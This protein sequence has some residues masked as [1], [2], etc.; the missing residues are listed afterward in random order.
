MSK[1]GQLLCIEVFFVKI[2]FLES[3]ADYP[4]YAQSDIFYIQSIAK[5]REGVNNLK[6]FFHWAVK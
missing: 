2:S 1:R 4:F 3:D 5:K 6:L